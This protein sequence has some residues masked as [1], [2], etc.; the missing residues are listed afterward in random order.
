MSVLFLILSLGTFPSLEL[1]PEVLKIPEGAGGDQ[2]H[3][4]RGHYENIHERN[5][6][7]QM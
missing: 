6:R 2:S 4:M 3:R 1:F 5:L 7:M